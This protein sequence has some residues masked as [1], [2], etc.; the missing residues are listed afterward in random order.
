MGYRWYEANHV[1]PVFPFGF[2]LSYT[3]FSYSDLSVAS[4]VDAQ[5]HSAV[6]TVKYT[7][8]N[9]GSREG[10]EAS[11]V[12]LTLPAEAGEPSKRLV[13]FQKVDLMPDTSQQVTVTID[14][15]TSNHPLSYW[16]PE[17]DAPVAGWANGS[18]NTAPG[19]YTV[20]IGSSSADT[21][22]EQTINLSFSSEPAPA[23]P[24]P[25]TGNAAAGGGGGGGAFAILTLLTLAI[26]LAARRRQFKLGAQTG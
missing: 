26:L 11:Q 6:L 10:A 12:Y 14:S 25:T 16:V 15:S 24:P 22:L 4:T 17:N 21:P 1:T 8:N 13:G 5:T 18:W 19:D 7:I 2:G 9:T 23:P 20:H 3:T